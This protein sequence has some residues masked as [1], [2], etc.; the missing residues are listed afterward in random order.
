MTTPNVRAAASAPS[1]GNAILLAVYSVTIFLSAFLLFMVQPMFSKMVLPRLGGTPAVWNTC[2]LFFQAALLMGYLYAHLASRWLGPRRHALPHLVLLAL[3]LITLPISLPDGSIPQA[4]ESPIPWLLGVLAV[5]LGLPF[6]IMSA[7]GPLLQKWFSDTGHPHAANPYFLYAASNVGSLLALLSYPLLIEPRLRLAEQTW[8]WAAGYAVLLVL[9]AGCAF[10]LARDRRE[11]G[12]TATDAA[13]TG[14]PAGAHEPAPG[15]RRRAEWILFAFVPS[16]LLLGVTHFLTTDVAAVPLLWILPLALYLLTFV[17]VFSRRQLIPHRWVVLAHP[18]LA[19][20]L[21]FTIVAGQTGP[22]ALLFPLHLIVFFALA[23]ATHGELARRRPTAR[24][25][26]EF[27]LWMSVG[28]VLGGIF[29][30]LI[31]PNIFD[32]VFEYPLMIGAAAVLRPALATGDVLTPTARRSLAVLTGLL[33]GLL[34]ILAFGSADWRTYLPMLLPYLALLCSVAVIA[35]RK[36]FGLAVTAVI[37]LIPLAQTWTSD[38]LYQERTFFAV[39]RVM[40]DDGGRFHLYGHGTT[41][42]GAQLREPGR[43]TEPLGY[44]SV[45]SPIGQ[46]FATV[47]GPAAGRAVGIVGLGTGALACYAEP[48]D[49]WTFYEID[50]VVETIARNPGFF[51]YLAEC[52]PSAP[53]ILGDARI[54]LEDVPDDSYDVLVLDAFSS[55]A[56][57]AHLVTREALE[58]YLEKTRETG[59]II[60]HISNRHLDMEPVLAALARDSDLVALIGDDDVSDAQADER[61]Y[62]SRWVTIARDVEDLGALPTMDGWRNSRERAGVQLWTDDFSNILGIVSWGR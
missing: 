5:S 15:L 49:E 51:S 27:Y 48:G 3:A 28:G 37:L 31:A 29:N 21:L 8:L 43:T 46:F 2:M 9:F 1:R 19:L 34:L 39:H 22:T 61:I 25:L 53:V 13:V 38:T 17:L 14:A 11:V 52:T 47:P 7:S 62:S 10:L 33:V 30:V 4:G 56:I 57:P 55:D 44:Y 54:M 40:A 23:L 26:T 41:I 24:H 20:L 36:M 42:H 60:F 12:G 32:S 58:L 6:F 16:S 18:P 45:S 50:P 59:V 35:H